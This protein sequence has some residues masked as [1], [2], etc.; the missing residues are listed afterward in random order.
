MFYWIDLA[1]GFSAPMLVFLLLGMKKI[2]RFSWCIF[3]VGAAIGLTW[4]I[5]MFVGS[6]VTTALATIITIRPYPVHYSIFVISHTL[7]D[8]GLFLIGYWL[9]LLLCKSPQFE[10][11]NVKEILVLV[12]YGQIQ[13]FMVEMGATA[14]DA[15]AFVVYWWNPALFHWNGHPITLFPQLCWVYGSIVFYLLLRKLKPKFQTP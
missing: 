4:E 2:S 5:P 13:E 12:G 10:S 15:W 14:N 6:N 1:I 9:V 8:G 3:W 7:W 11:F